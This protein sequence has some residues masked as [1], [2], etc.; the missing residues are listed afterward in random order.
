[1]SIESLVIKQA[2]LSDLR[3]G[4]KAQGREESDKCERQRAGVNTLGMVTTESCIGSVYKGW[5]DEAAEASMYHCSG[6][7]FEDTW[8]NCVLE[9][10]V[11][12][13]CQNVRSL[14]KKRMA[15]GRELGGVRAAI[16]R[17]GRRLALEESA[18]PS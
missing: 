16:T 6:P 14:K 9:D 10:E 17:V 13:H 1:M 11:C 7:D 4:L 5:M 15:A 18:C 8:E 2:R 3:R 12:Q